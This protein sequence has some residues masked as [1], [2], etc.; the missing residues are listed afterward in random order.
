VPTP[1]RAHSWRERPAIAG[2][3]PRHPERT[4]LYKTLAEHF[5]T[6]LKRTSAGQFECQGDRHP[7]PAYVEQAF[8]KYLECGIF[9]P[10][11]TP[12]VWLSRLRT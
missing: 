8:R 10:R 5:E 3:N 4:L 7:P 6:W 12:A 2:N 9:S 11:A 1:R